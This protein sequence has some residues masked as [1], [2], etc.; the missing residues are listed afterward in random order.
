MTLLSSKF[1][2]D[3]VKR[4][5]FQ[6]KK[7]ESLKTLQFYLVLVFHLSEFVSQLLKRRSQIRFVSPTFRHYFIP[8]TKGCYEY[9]GM[10]FVPY[11]RSNLF[12]MNKLFCS[13][14]PLFYNK[15][16]KVYNT[17]INS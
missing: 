8:E 12:S 5:N 10:S 11:K 13:Q 1:D 9:L 15:G 2:G 17:V 14:F 16:E 3:R 4:S 7:K 6:K